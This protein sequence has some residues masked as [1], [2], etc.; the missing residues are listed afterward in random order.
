V[1]LHSLWGRCPA[2]V[3]CDMPRKIDWTL[4]A[5]YMASSSNTSSIDGFIFFLLEHLKYDF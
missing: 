1:E 2:M 3:E 4:E 5:D